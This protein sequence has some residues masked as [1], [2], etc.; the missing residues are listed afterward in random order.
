MRNFPPL[1][2]T[3]REIVDRLT[4]DG[5]ISNID[6]AAAVHLSTSAC[7]RRVRAWRSAA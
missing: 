1:D 6:L 3:D 2:A 7:L 5:R 4:A